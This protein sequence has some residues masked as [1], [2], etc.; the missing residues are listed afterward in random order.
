MLSYVFAMSDNNAAVPEAP[1]FRLAETLELD[2]FRR[3]MAPNVPDRV[4]AAIAGGVQTS[5]ALTLADVS[6]LLDVDGT[7]D[8]L[9]DNVIRLPDG[10]LVVACLT[11]MPGVSSA[12]WDWWFGWHSYTSERYR[13]WHPKDHLESSLKFDRRDAATSRAGYVGNTSF[14][15]EYIGG[16]LQRLEIRFIEPSS[17]GLDQSRVDEIGVAICARTALRKERLAAGW[18]I[19]LVEDTADGCRMHSRFFLG[20]ARSEL[21]VVGPLISR[22]VSSGSMR[23]RLLPDGTATALLR[24]CSEEMNHLASILPELYAQFGQPED[25]VVNLTAEATREKQ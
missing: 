18:L 22:F 2:S 14:V 23:R 1:G 6:K 7:G 10:Q 4:E 17:M 8:G 11:E 15:D 19:H 13:L 3:P 21:P 9:T 20:D 24:H 25:A 5:P 16:E 12:M